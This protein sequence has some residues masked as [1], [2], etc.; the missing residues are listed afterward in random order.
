L[1]AVAQLQR[2]KLFFVVLVGGTGH[3]CFFRVPW[4]LAPHLFRHQRATIVNVVIAIIMMTVVCGNGASST[5]MWQ[6]A[7]ER[8]NNK[9]DA[10]R[11]RLIE[12]WTF[13]WQPDDDMME[14]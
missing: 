14:E 4:G 3:P 12:A 9:P 6:R 11:H 5:G 13:E 10:I 2:G 1:L 7:I 8:Y